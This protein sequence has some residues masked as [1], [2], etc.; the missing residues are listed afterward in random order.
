LT[1]NY[2]EDDKIAALRTIYCNPEPANPNQVLSIFDTESFEKLPKPIQRILDTTTIAPLLTAERRSETPDFFEAVLLFYQ[3]NPNLSDEA[4]EQIIV[5]IRHNQVLQDDLI[6]Q[7]RETKRSSSPAVSEMSDITMDSPPKLSDKKD[8]EDEGILKPV[9]KIKPTKGSGPSLS[10]QASEL[11]QKASKFKERLLN[12]K[13]S[14]ASI[15]P[16][17][18]DKDVSV[19]SDKKPT[20]P[21]SRK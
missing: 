15:S 4:Y 16:I 8:L 12:F 18:N 11:K 17:T 1:E 10:K 3:A 7:Y 2:L 20:S 13:S 9:I 21:T 14:G 19:E 6:H 5:D